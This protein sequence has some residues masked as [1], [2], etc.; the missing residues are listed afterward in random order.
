M[1]RTP[2]AQACGS[3]SRQQEHA[4]PVG[5]QALDG[6]WRRCQHVAQAMHDV[7]RGRQQS[8]PDNAPDAAPLPCWCRA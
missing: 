1:S 3:A 4:R 6:G 2:L 7:G 8:L 5:R